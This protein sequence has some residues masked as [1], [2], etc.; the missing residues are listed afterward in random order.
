LTALIIDCDPGIDDA[1][2]VLVAAGSREFEIL[3]VTTVAG[4]RPLEVTS[5][6]ACRILDAASREDV[7]V[8]SGC[9]R[10]LTH[11]AP[12]CNLVHGEDG[13]GGVAMPA[14]RSPAPAHATHFLV[15]ALRDAPIGSITLVAVGPLTNLA[16]AEVMH[17]GNSASRAIAARHGRRRISS[18]QRH[19][20][21]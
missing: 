18:G 7:P 5:L 6:N 8:Y 19:A 20:E 10:P 2:A 14:R 16:V 1:L 4:N 12:R 9:P 17:P 15:E 21:R 3:G 13:L 11:S